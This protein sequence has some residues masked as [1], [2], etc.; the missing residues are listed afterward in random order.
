MRATKQ[1]EKEDVGG[2]EEEVSRGARGQ[3]IVSGNVFHLH[4]Y[5]VNSGEQGG[6]GAGGVHGTPF[7]AAIPIRAGDCCAPADRAG[8]ERKKG[9]RERVQLCVIFFK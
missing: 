8:E 7:T 9:Q 2:E 5:T 1:K 3:L 4:V 6:G